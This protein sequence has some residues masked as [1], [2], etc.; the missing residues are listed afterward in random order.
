MMLKGKLD[1]VGYLAKKS[2]EV[3]PFQSEGPA[4]VYKDD[5][6]EEMDFEGSEA[7]EEIEEIDIRKRQK[8]V[9]EDEESDDGEERKSSH[10]KMQIDDSV[11]EEGGEGDGESASD[12]AE[13]SDEVE[14][15]DKM[16]K[17]MESEDSD[18][19]IE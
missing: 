9:S 11:S 19:A 1:M 3:K 15:G 5:S 4:I 8:K 6:D 2:G 16:M 18:S 7:D 10:R 17:M 14:K 12:L 13:D